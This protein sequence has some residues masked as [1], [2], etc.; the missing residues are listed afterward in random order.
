ML[1]IPRKSILVLGAAAA[2]VALTTTTALAAGDTDDS[3]SPAST[4]FTVSNSGNIT[5]AGTLDGF[6]F[7]V[8]CTDVTMTA[9]TRASG[10]T[11]SVTSN[12]D[13]HNAA[14]DCT[15]NHGG[16]D[17]VTSAGTWSLTEVDAAS[18]AHST[19]PQSTGDQLTINI[20]NNGATFVSS[21]VP[22]CTVTAQSSTPTSSSFNDMNSATYSSA[23]V[24]VTVSGFFCT[25][26]PTATLSGTFTSSTNIG[27]LT[28]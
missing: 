23:T 10:L 11:A 8:T 22:G 13:F 1:R 4:S 16:T 9:K 25:T 21:F 24:N 26:S 27:D 2:V 5:F 28:T 15:D 7:T 17:T 6:S 18:D 14:K 3:L 19:E 20:P 12:P